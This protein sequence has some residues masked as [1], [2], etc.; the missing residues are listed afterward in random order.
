VQV[1][2][3]HCQDVLNLDAER[4]H[5]VLAKYSLGKKN[6]TNELDLLPYILLIVLSTGNMRGTT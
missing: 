3:Q 1:V 6:N 2:I 4:I 5:M